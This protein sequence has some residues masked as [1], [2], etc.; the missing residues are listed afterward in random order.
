V[1]LSSL[2]VKVR[3]FLREQGIG[4]GGMVVAVSGGP[5][6]VA[7]L[8]A[9][10][11]LRT[12]SRT[13]CPSGA[14]GLLVIAHLNHQLRGGESLADEQF[15]RDLHAALLARGITAL[16]LR[17][18]R[19]DVTAHAQAAGGNLESV[20]RRLR[21]DW[22]ARVAQDS[23]VPFL[24]TG[25]T[26]DDQ[27][28]T[29]LHRLLRGTGL[30][31][32]SG[33]A[34]RRLLPPRIEVVRPLLQVTRAEVL[35]YLE[36]EGQAYCQDSSNANLDFTRNRI[37][38][39]LLPHLA[40]HYNPAIVSVLG[41]LAGQAVEAYQ[42]LQVLAQ[43]LLTESELPRAGKMLVFDQKRLATRPRH[44][45]REVFRLAW[46]RENW[47]LGGMGFREWDRLAALVFGEARAV[48]L[49]GG[50]RAER[51]ERVVRIGPVS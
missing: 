20:A 30:Q 6:S 19:I 24:A 34:A 33:I 13:I 32:L 41:R 18:E 16:Q 8:R 4:P 38:H 28:E 36:A 11:A 47:R 46:A 23:K 44:L 10:V 26:A 29:V 37:R 3:Q 9:L 17:C 5:D 49:P 48:D 25:H 2:V 27:A 45:V 15:V 40:R 42:D 43:E 50:I 31:G 51:G 1:K 39:E 35:T 22:L 21:Y 7:L 14:D 12:E